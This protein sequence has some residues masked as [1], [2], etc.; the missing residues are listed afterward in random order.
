MGLDVLRNL[1][2]G[3]KILPNVTSLYLSFP[4]RWLNTLEQRQ[5]FKR[6]NT[7]CP[8]ITKLT[9]KTH[10]V[11]FL[12]MLRKEQI[13]IVLGKDE[14]LPNEDVMLPNEDVMLPNE[15]SDG[16]LY[17]KNGFDVFNE[18]GITVLNGVTEIKGC[19]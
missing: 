14:L 10:S 6:L 16:I 15:D 4:E 8:N 9:M 5:L 7:R 2:D 18:E 13:K 19:N 3:D 11:Y 1:F 12:Q 17:R